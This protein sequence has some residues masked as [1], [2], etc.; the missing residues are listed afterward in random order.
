MIK[1]IS[2]HPYFKQ[3]RLMLEVL[4]AVAAEE[5]FALKGGTAINFFMRNMPRLS[6]DIDLT[7]LP[8]EDRKT[9]LNNID[10]ALRR[11]AARFQKISPRAMIQEGL[12]KGTRS[13][14]KLY[15]DDGE[16]Q[17]IIEPN[18]TLRGT[19][20]AP[21]ILKVSP[22]VAKIFGAS[23]SITVASMADVYGGKICAALDRQ[24][25]RDLFDVKV[26]FENEG[27]SDEI[28]KGFVLYLVGHDETMSQLLAPVRKDISEIYRTQFD[29]MSLEPVTLESLLET[30]ERL[31]QTLQSTLTK[32]ERE[33]LLSVK[34][35]TPKWEL[36]GIPGIERFPAIQWKIS[37]IKKMKL[38]HHEKS[39]ERLRKI[40]KL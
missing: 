10:T 35:G 32:S 16:A 1:Q 40:L 5:C 28:R 33:F 25:P 34:R 19:F 9:S 24:H 3:A 31:I 21:Q 4:S 26:L 30:R 39:V 27:L 22:Q 23:V 20:Y 11:I 12:V 38:E 37:N 6:V 8:I 13:V 29:G 14:S 7:Y 15:I 2:E 18:L 36:L 17:V